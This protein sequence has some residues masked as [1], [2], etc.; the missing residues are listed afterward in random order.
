MRRKLAV[1]LCLALALPALADVTLIDPAGSNKAKVDANGNLR[2]APGESTR[3]TYECTATGLAT[4][5]AFNM[6]IEASA[7]TGFKLSSYCVGLSNA[8]AAALVTVNVNRRTTAS[9]GGTVAANEATASPSM[10]KMDPADGSYGGICRITSTLGTIGPLLDGQGFTVGELGA[11]AADPPGPA[12]FCKFYG[13]NE[14]KMPTV[15]AGATNGLSITVT[16]PGAG[17]L[18]A[19][20]IT[21]T[22]IAE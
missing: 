4:T 2:F 18:A 8:T 1:L 16:A 14:G 3:P 10:S 21:A 22:I 15:L 17:G 6:T 9:S 7:G 5:A 13:L 20:S 12:A 11:G 19:G